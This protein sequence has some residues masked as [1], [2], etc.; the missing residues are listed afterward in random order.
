MNGGV[1]VFVPDSAAVCTVAETPPS[2]FIATCTVSVSHFSTYG[3]IAPTNTDNDGVLDLFPPEEDNCPTVPNPGQEDSD[4]DGV[5]DTCDICPG[6]DDSL[7]TDQD[8]V[9]D[10]CD[11]CPGQDDG[12]AG[13]LGDD[14]ADGVINCNDQCA[15]VDD[16]VFSPGCVGAVPAISVWGMIVMTLFLFVAGKI[17]YGWRRQSLAK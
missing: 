14:D 9:P 6:S 17:M 1:G 2:T 12:D 15:G 16:G 11:Q 5:G 3:L 10:G 8:S 13:A 4:G 7:D